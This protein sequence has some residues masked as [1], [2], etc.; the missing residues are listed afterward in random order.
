M[1]RVTLLQPPQTQLLL[2]RAYI[3]LG[4]GSL[5]AVLEESDVDVDI[6]NL[7]DCGD[8]DGVEIPE[9]DWYGISCV[10]ATLPATKKLVSRLRG[11]GKTVVG[12]AHPSVLPEETY[13]QIKPDVV[14]S[15]EAEYLFRDLVTGA[16]EPEPIMQAGLIQDLNSLPFPARHLFDRED[17]VDTTGIHG[18]EKGVPATTVSTG[19]GCP[20]SCAFCCKGHPMFNWYRYRSTDLVYEE[21]AYLKKEYAVE[22]VRFVDDEFTLHTQRTAELMKKMVDLDLGFVCITRADTLNEPLLSLMEEAGCREVHIG[23]ETGSDRLLRLMNKQTTSD[24]LLNGVHMIKEAGIRV[25]AY[26]MMN[27]PGETEEDRKLTVEWLREAQPDKFTLSVFTALPGSAI[28][29]QVKTVTPWYYLD[30]DGDFNEYRAQLH[31]VLGR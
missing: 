28:A 16:V 22:H 30:D 25:K 20:F 23:V 4:L 15:G 10:S 29:G 27:F 7:A 31:E 3:P 26:L 2:P 19:R 11:Q 1:V 14:M 13:S 17:V 12:G 9:S 24:S 6:L 5:A 8:I 21:L 18:Q